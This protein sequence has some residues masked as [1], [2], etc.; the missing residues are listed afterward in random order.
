MSLVVVGSIGIDTVETPSTRREDVL[1]G[2]ASYFAYA[3]SFFT[4]VSLVGVVGRDFP[5]EYRSLLEKRDI[6][7]AGLEVADG[8]TF[9]WTGKYHENM[10]DRD[11]L[12]VHLNV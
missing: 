4:R 8:K 3:A 9:R 1:G 6:D 5:S 12:E 11:T 7:L 10:A 2:S